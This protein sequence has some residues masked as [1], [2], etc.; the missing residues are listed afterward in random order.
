MKQLTLLCMT[1]A[2]LA[3]LSGCGDKPKSDAAKYKYSAAEVYKETCLHCHGNK[4]EGN[5]EKKAPAINKQSIQELEMSL[6]DIKNGGLGQ[7]TASEHEVMEHNMK[8][9]A[10]KGYDYDIKVMA[11]YIFNTFNISK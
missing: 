11:S 6:F 1:V 2:S 4:G 9:L 7:S 10:E 5:P 3:L 8:K